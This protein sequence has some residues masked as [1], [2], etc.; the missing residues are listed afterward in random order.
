MNRKTTA[1]A[2]ALAT[3]AATGSASAQPTDERPGTV[4]P[5]TAA[6]GSRPSE[7]AIKG[8]VS[9]RPGI[10]ERVERCN[11]LQGTLREQCLRDAMNPS[12]GAS[13]PAPPATGAAKPRSPD[14]PPPQNPR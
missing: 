12:A 1:A 5:G 11:S 13:R 9:D 8:G 6:D 2:F 7:G 10:E 4:P 3:I 14:A